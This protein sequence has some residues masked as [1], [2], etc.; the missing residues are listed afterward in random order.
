MSAQVG[1]VRSVL[2]TASDRAW[3]KV[4]APILLPERDT[5]GAA[6]MSIAVMN[7]LWV[8]SPTSG[9]ERLVLLPRHGAVARRTQGP[10]WSGSSRRWTSSRNISGSTR[11]SCDCA[12][13][14]TSTPVRELMGGGVVHVVGGFF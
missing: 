9:N 5:R 1:D 3:Q 12:T 11:S 2:A 4:F 13:S 10:R 6:A 7:R 8:N 14:P